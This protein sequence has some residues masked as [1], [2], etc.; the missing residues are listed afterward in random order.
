M[1]SRR[2][3][4]QV[5]NVVLVLTLAVATGRAT[6]SGQQAQASRRPNAYGTTAD[7]AYHVGSSEFVPR[8][9]GTTYDEAFGIGR[10]S[11]NCI[12]GCLIASPHVP[13]GAL[14]TGITGYF[15]DSNATYDVGVFVATAAAD[16]TGFQTLTEVTSNGAA[17]GC[18]VSSFLDLTS[19][20]YQV[21]YGSNELVLLGDFHALDGTVAIEGVTL[22]YRLQVSPAPPT[23]TFN[24]VPVTDPAFQFIEALAAAGITAGCGGGNYCP[25]A[26][27]TRRQMAVY[28][29]KALGL[30]WQ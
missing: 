9:S 7:S 2:H 19:L 27:V 14:L 28:L 5:R 1:R 16:G 18:G 10:Y 11:S 24:D 8:T 23:A 17:Q 12:G 21:D 6:A 29:A 20:N 30:Q 26:P 4:I 3:R 15:C 25:D 13:D 22:Y